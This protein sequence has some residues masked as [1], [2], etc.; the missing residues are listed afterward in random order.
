MV[1]STPPGAASIRS[2]TADDAGALAELFWRVRSESVP[3]IPMIAHDR[4]TVEPFVRD[5]MLREFEVWLAELD[6][7]VVG[8]LALVRPDV[9]G[10]LYLAAPHTNQGLGGRF[11]ALAKEQFP[12]GLQLWAFQ[13]NS[14]ALR[15]YE[16]HGFVPV[17][18]T[19]GDNEEGEPDVRMV[20]RP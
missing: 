17:E 6:G 2:A 1:T 11:I 13:S 8:F 9:L 5:V 16:R 19:D 18:W 7:C 12:D 4:S 20:W 15:F 3:E 10:H 14:R